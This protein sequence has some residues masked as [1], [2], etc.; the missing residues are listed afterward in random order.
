MTLLVVGL[1][2]FLGVH[3]VPA[4]P[5]WRRALVTRHGE[6]GYKR[7]FSLAS[8]LG[9]LLIIV[10]FAMSE[11]GP[12]LFTPVAGA[13]M[14]APL[15]VTL[16]FILLAAANMRGYLRATLRHP[17]LIG[18]LLWSGV[19]FL[20]NGSTRATILFGAFFVWAVLDLVAAVSRPST[21]IFAPQAKYDAMSVVGGIVVALAVMSVHRWLFG[22]SVVPF[23]F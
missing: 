10:G 7:Y 19:H 2:L 12:Q 15:L 6:D 16:A 4:I 13:R 9:F 23:S 18:V 5:A 22:V 14:V 17:M 8:G 3:L 21:R 20:A 11:R 1:I